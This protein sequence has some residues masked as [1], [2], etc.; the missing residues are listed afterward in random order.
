MRFYK[1][2]RLKLR[3]LTDII[4]TRQLNFDNKIDFKWKQ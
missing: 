3:F 4:L 1:I 2:N